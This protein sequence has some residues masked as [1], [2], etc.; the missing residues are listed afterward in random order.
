VPAKYVFNQGI[1]TY[2]RHAGP[3]SLP[4]ESPDL[5]RGEVVL[6]IHHTGGNCRNFDTLLAS[7]SED[8]SPLAF[9]LPGHD[10]SGSQASLG[11]IDAMAEFAVT[12]LDA[13]SVSRPVVVLGHGMGACVALQMAL[14][15]PSRIG[16]LVLASGGGAYVCGQDLIDRAHLV[17]Q[18]KARREFEIEAY[19]KGVAPKIMR[20]GFMDT[21]KTDPRVIHHNLIAQRDWKGAERLTEIGVPSLVCGGEHSPEP[22]RE[23]ANRLLASLQSTNARVVHEV[24]S[25]AGH[26]FPMEKTDEFSQAVTRFLGDLR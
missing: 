23:E 12:L 24:L 18:G 3:T 10:R 6:C 20:A 8:H 16:A 1:A 4:E 21:L 9:D 17:S 11:S 5:S 22:I 2:L 13:L 7:L 15:H 19:A 25:G 26:M 14:D